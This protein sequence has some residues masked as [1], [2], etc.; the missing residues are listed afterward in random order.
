MTGRAPFSLF[1]R[2]LPAN[3][4][5]LVA[6][7]LDDCLEFLEGFHFTGTGRSAGC[8]HLVD[9]YDTLAGARAA[10]AVCQ[11]RAGRVRHRRPGAA[12]RPDRF[13]RSARRWVSRPTRPR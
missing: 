8:E 11:R 4:G 1:V 12:E 7:G 2:R 6:A 5:F 10:I 13:R 9:T 3:R